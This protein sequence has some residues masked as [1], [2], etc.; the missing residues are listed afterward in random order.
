MPSEVA[1]P[2]QE[3]VSC[4]SRFMWIRTTCYGCEEPF[5]YKLLNGQRERD[6]CSACKKEM[7]LAAKKEA[8]T[9][10]AEPDVS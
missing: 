4:N 1:A 6:I 3:L 5:R 8:A 10:K 7:A 2:Y 9:K